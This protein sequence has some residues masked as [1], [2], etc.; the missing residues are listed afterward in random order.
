MRKSDGELIN[1]KEI[2]QKAEVRRWGKPKERI[3][4]QHLSPNR[5]YKKVKA[6]EDVRIEGLKHYIGANC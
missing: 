2:I 5:N 3:N 4:L 6:F 1:M